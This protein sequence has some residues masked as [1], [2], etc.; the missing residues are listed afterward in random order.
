MDC[1]REQ[2]VLASEGNRRDWHWKLIGDVKD[3]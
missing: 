2:R 1:L 3:E